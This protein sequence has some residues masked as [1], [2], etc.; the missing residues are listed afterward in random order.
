MSATATVTLQSEASKLR[1]RA[2]RARVTTAQSLKNTHIIEL[3]MTPGSQ[4][5]GVIEGGEDIE[6]SSTIIICAK[7]EQK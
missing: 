6:K 4:R 2:Q 5:V 3:H 1:K 7:L